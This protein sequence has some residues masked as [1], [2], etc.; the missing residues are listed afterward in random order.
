MIVVHYRV[1]D[2]EEIPTKDKNELQNWMYKLYQEKDAMLE[3]FYAT[4]QFPVNGQSE[5][6]INQY[7]SC[8]RQ[9]CHQRWKYYFS[10]SD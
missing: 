9:I 2:V 4:G 3:K 8:K 1:F 7:T 10:E 5:R 6:N